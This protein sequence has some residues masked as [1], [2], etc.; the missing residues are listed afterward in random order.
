[1]SAEEV[2]T[3][4]HR[5]LAAAVVVARS[6]SPLRAAQ[7]TLGERFEGVAAMVVRDRTERVLLD[8]ATLLRCASST[9]PLALFLRDTLV[10]NIL[11]DAVFDIVRI[12]EEETAHAHGS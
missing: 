1:M 9:T 6:A 8:D 3:R 2:R 11:V 10:V 7:R 5:E 12:A 4:V